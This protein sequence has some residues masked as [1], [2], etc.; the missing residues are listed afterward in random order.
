MVIGIHNAFGKHTGLWII[1]TLSENIH[2]GIWKAPG[3]LQTQ[4]HGGY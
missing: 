3:L 4:T 2:V 1:I